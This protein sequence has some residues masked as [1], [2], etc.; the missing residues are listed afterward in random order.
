MLSSDFAS[1]YSGI[2][3]IRWQRKMISP[4][5]N[6]LKA[7]KSNQKNGQTLGRLGLQKAGICLGEGN[8]LVIVR[9][10][11]SYPHKP[12]CPSFSGPNLYGAWLSS[13]KSLYYLLIKHL[14]I[15]FFSIVSPHLWLEKGGCS[16]PG[17]L[18]DDFMHLFSFPNILLF[19]LYR[20][21]KKFK[22]ASVHLFYLF[23]ECAYHLIGAQW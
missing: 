15:H 2:V 17:E 1:H 7:S 12:A 19:P 6:Y 21:E 22:D 14:N 8:G 20:L 13:H 10:L 9:I 5:R 16:L 11:F 4:E 18:L 23:S 3:S